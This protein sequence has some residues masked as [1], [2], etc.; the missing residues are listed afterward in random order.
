MDVTEAL[1][2]SQ[3]ATYS[4][5][6]TSLQS[7]SDILTIDGT[8]RAITIKDSQLLFGVMGDK[9]VER[10]YFKCPR[11]VGDNI[12][13]S[14]HQIY[15]SYVST[16][17]QN[18]TSFSSYNV[19]KYHCDDVTVNAR[20]IDFSWL[21]SAN[22]LQN[23][24]FIAFK[25]LAQYSDGETLKTRW[26]TTPAYGTVLL[27]VPDGEFIED[28]Y[29]DVIN[30]LFTRLEILEAGGASDEKINEAVNSYLSTNP[31]TIATASATEIGG[32]KAE[33][34]GEDD[35]VPVKIKADGTLAVP[36]YPVST[37]GIRLFKPN[38]KP[39]LYLVGIDLDKAKTWMDGFYQMGSDGMVITIHLDSS[40]TFAPTENMSV[41]KNAMTYATTLGLPINSI[42]FHCTLDALGT[43]T[44]TYELYKNQVLAVLSEIGSGIENV[45]VF[46]EYP[47][48]YLKAENAPY[49]VETVNAIK[50]AGY[51]VGISF[52]YPGECARTWREQTAVVDAL[53][54]LGSNL[55]PRHGYRGKAITLGDSVFAWDMTLAPYK[56]LKEAYPDKP[57]ILTET[58]VQHYWE[59]LAAPSSYKWSSMSDVTDG[60][61]NVAKTY[62]YGL[63]NNHDANGL[64]QDVWVWFPEQ[65]LYPEFYE[66]VCEY[67]GRSPE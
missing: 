34:A 14:Q 39:Q 51:K 41:V 32:I 31:V 15:I 43:D 23:A 17:S 37:R 29:P 50:D 45:T 9:D 58:G 63:F 26:N 10:K 52:T 19:G 6:G 3:A 8:T 62:F 22:V 64:F 11:F 59:A 55:Y 33:D 2:A 67:T 57:F 47:N 27:T 12:D 56:R 16:S 21:L 30:Q 18:A 61:G 66:F 5:T 20:T 65:M 28:E 13:L 24:G 42:K 48:S 53:D 54:I 46:N 36:T 4:T 35:T 40:G 38:F 7:S 49:V 25:V 1:A 44:T 60:E